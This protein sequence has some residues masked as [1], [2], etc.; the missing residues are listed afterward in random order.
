M[1]DLKSDI[2]FEIANGVLGGFRL[3]KLLVHGKSKRLS[4]EP[5]AH[6]I[7]KFQ[8]YHLNANGVEVGH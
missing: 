5:V 6:L 1:T 4:C 7:L 8:Q 3:T 2:G